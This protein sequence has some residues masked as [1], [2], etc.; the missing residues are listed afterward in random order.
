MKKTTL[1][2]ATVK[3]ATWLA[4]LGLVLTGCTK[5]TPYE[6]LKNKEEDESKLVLMDANSK[7][8][9]EYLYVAST[10]NSSRSSDVARPYWQGEEKIVKFQ[11]TD[12]TL[13]VIEIEKRR[14]FCA[15]CHK[16]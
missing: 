11:F 14:S 1:L 9:D 15:K 6:G 13:D 7:Q 5:K 10:A 2:K 12:K 3:A 8:S 16:Q 4:T